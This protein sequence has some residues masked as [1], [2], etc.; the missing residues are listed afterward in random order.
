MTS[1]G[2]SDACTVFVWW[3]G[4][5]VLFR[6]LLLNISCP[7]NEYDLILGVSVG[8]INGV[9][10]AQG[11]LKLM[12][13]FWEDIND[14]HPILGV[15][16]FLKLAIWRW[17]GW[18]SLSPM[19]DLLKGHVSLSKLQTPYGCGV[20]ARENSEYYTML[21]SEMEKDERLWKSI[22]ASAAIAALMEPVLMKV[23]DDEKPMIMSDGGHRHVLPVPPEET[24]HVDAIFCKPHHT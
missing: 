9:L 19:V 10:A 6:C 15:K 12:R 24:T 21:A 16:G 14:K 1:L 4:L 13:K 18:F 17:R 23:D 2:A 5:K 7:V 20:V 8:S 11:D 3:W 22:E